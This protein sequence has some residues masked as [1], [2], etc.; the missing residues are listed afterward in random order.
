[1]SYSTQF[2]DLV[3]VKT[4][5]IHIERIFIFITDLSFSRHSSCINGLLKL[6]D[7]ERHGETIDRGLM[8][9]LIRMLIDLH[10]RKLG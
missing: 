6:I 5:R 2:N 1:M 10:V 9:N 3:S 4:N 8:K 7:Q